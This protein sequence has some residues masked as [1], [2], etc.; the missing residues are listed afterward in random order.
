MGPRRDIIKEVAKAVRA[1]GMKFGVY[2]SLIEWFHPL[3]LED[4]KNTMRTHKFVDLKVIPELK[5]LVQD[6]KPSIVWSDG[7]WQAKDGYFKS[8]SFLAWLYNE[9]PVKDEVVVN[10]RW[11]KNTHCYHGGF[12]N[13][14]D[15][16]NPGK[17]LSIMQT[18][19]I[20]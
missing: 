11:G 19:I 1:K 10:D 17:P 8:K 13:C 3:Y 7:V 20:L 9:S 6:Y 5:Q 18:I 16:Y 12:F 15:R 2:Y 4:M 14:K